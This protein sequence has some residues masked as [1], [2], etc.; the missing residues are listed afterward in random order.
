MIF[1]LTLDLSNKIDLQMF[2]KDFKPSGFFVPQQQISVEDVT[3]ILEK[4]AKHLVTLGMV[5]FFTIE[6]MAW[7]D[8]TVFFICAQFY[9]IP[10]NAFVGCQKTLGNQSQTIPVIHPSQGPNSSPRLRKRVLYKR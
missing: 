7:T 5:G 9:A 3:A 10:L 1:C 2:D 6:L 8:D 4:V